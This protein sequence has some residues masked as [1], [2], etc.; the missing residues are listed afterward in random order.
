[1]KQAAFFA[2]AQVAVG[3]SVGIGKEKRSRAIY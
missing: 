1:V 2:V 3:H